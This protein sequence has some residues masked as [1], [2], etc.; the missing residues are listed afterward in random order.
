MRTLL[1]CSLPPAGLEPGGV[2]FLLLVRLRFPWGS[3]SPDTQ[4]NRLS[5]PPPSTPT[6]TPPTDCGFQDTWGAGWS[7]LR[8]KEAILRLASDPVPR[9]L[10]SW[11]SSR[12][13]LAPAAPAASPGS[14]H[15]ESYLPL[16]SEGGSAGDLHLARSRGS[17]GDGVGD[18]ELAA[19][20][21][22]RKVK[23]QAFPITSFSVH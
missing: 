2:E 6:P 11:A 5:F 12:H 1:R 16:S 18:G 9:P 7:S 4:K 10:P 15:S 23:K 14:D 3:W 19:W 17:P 21:V 13:T 22:L 20:L 8:T